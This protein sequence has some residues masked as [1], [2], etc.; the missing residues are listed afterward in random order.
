MSEDRTEA[1]PAVR[2][3][4][5]NDDPFERRPVNITNDP[6]KIFHDGGYITA[7]AEEMIG[8]KMAIQ[9]AL[10]NLNQGVQE[11]KNLKEANKNL[12][13]ESNRRGEILARLSHT[14]LGRAHLIS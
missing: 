6:S 4:N 1:Q 11:N 14:T 3:H 13:E 12:A 5:G 9:M 7:S 2:D 8:N 10:N